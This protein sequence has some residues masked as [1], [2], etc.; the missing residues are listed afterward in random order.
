MW[1]PLISLLK[2]VCNG[3]EY[4]SENGLVD[5]LNEEM[6][7]ILLY[8]YCSFKN[9]MLEFVFTHTNELDKTL[10]SYVNGQST[11]D[12]GTHITLMGEL[13]SGDWARADTAEGFA[14]NEAHALVSSYAQWHVERRIHS[15]RVLERSR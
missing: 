9:E 12:G 2:I 15:L 6:D 3:K 11:A 13:L 1:S 14:R 4:F 10:Y 7:G 5:L 8:L